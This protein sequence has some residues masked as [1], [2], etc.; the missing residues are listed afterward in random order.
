MENQNTEVLRKI[1]EAGTASE[2]WGSMLKI[3]DDN[4][5]F[6]EAQIIT[7]TSLEEGHEG[8]M[9]TDSEVDVLRYKRQL[10]K[11]LMECP[12]ALLEQLNRNEIRNKELDP[13]YKDVE[14]MR[15]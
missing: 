10:Q 9:L 6:L 11:D 15:A 5:K 13:F 3:M 7:K 2:F 14:E 8:E 4:V 1:L 12:S